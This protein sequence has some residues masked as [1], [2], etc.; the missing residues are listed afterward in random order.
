MR[1]IVLV[2]IL[3]AASALKNPCL[4]SPY[5]EQMWCDPT[6]P[7]S[8]RIDDLVSRLTL[9]EKIAA[10]GTDTPALPSVGM[11]R[12]NWW[13]EGTHGI[14]RLIK[15]DSTI[16]EVTNFAFP[17][18][19]AMSFNRTLWR[20]TGRRIATEARAAMNHGIAWSTYWA[21]VVNL[22][23]DPRWGRNIECPGEDPYVSGE[24]AAAFV[25]G[26]EHHPD[27]PSHLLA[28]SC[29]KH[30]VANSMEDSTVDGAHWDRFDF[31]AQI[32][33]RDLADS[34]MA[35]FQ[36]CVEKGRV[37][38]LMCSYNAVNGVPSCAN[39]WLLKTVARGEWQFDGY[40]TS[41]CGAD[42]DVWGQHNY[43]K[44]PGESV[45]KILAAGTD[46]DCGNFVPQYAEGALH[47][48]TITVA[49]ID[50]RLQMLFRVRMRLGHFDPPGPLQAIPPSEVCSDASQSIAHE[51][52]AQSVALVSNPKKVLPLRASSVK[53]AAVIGPMAD[54]ASAKALAGYYGSGN[55][56]GG[57][58]TTLADAIQRYVPSMRF[59]AGASPCTSNDTSGFAAAIRAAADADLVVLAVGSD[60]NVAREGHDATGISFPGVQQE[61]ISRVVAAA[62]GHVVVVM[63]TA[64]P[65]DIS[66]LLSNPRIHAVIH[67]GL[68][69]VQNGG[70]ADVIF[71]TRVPAGRLVQ[72]VYPQSFADEVSIF[73]F[74]MRPG[75]SPWPRPDC[76]TPPSCAN[77]T[78]PGR[79]HRFY[80]G[81]AVLPFGFG[82]SYTSF[83][84]QTAGAEPRAATILE[85]HVAREMRTDVDAG[86]S[87][88]SG[89]LYTVIDGRPV[90]D[91]LARSTNA[92]RAFPS[93][94]EQQTPMV[95]Y[96]VRVTNTGDLDAD[97]AVLGFL[98][99][100]G[101][102]KDGVPLQT[103]FAFE[104]VHVPAGQTVTVSLMPSAVDFTVVGADGVRQPLVG[105]WG[106]QFGVRETVA[107]GGGF[108][109]AA[110]RIV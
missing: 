46:V 87:A 92:G 85:Q 91:M 66:S 25:D 78:N 37:S 45:S 41:D 56:C 61:L 68:V 29:C 48:Q 19:T 94:A 43:T 95:S 11:E 2:S 59:E 5:K 10:L 3:A 86:A 62:K 109:T 1:C 6:K 58:I 27:D 17:I 72:T 52:S 51:G 102:G 34:Y 8:S 13:E 33:L 4:E 70:I 69:A 42:F 26:F 54:I 99:P 28:S 65:I 35:P 101:A 106:V 64:T 15:Y 12:Y 50:A 16:P 84:Y 75:Q 108:A 73:D 110:L 23:R 38:G 9:K 57:N 47:N 63:L 90:R 93:I 103:L 96:S 79:T 30:F 71:G 18:T 104:R 74:G 36:S 21:P 89:A 40:I 82:L 32:P 60:L 31:D 88:A 76:R 20:H 55:V 83:E 44:T 39:D 7:L 22:A 105:E 107:H 67:A 49:D 24:Y 80:T 98:T 97:D 14:S 53:S 100:P 81:R 77:G